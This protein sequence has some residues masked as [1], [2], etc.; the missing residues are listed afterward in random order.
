MNSTLLLILHLR[1]INDAIRALSRGVFPQTL[2]SDKDIR[3]AGRSIAKI[4]I[5]KHPSVELLHPEADYFRQNG[6]RFIAH[7]G[8]N[9]DIWITLKFQVGP[10]PAS[11]KLYNVKVYPVP[12]NNGSTDATKIK[13][14]PEYVVIKSTLD[15]KISYAP[16]TAAELSECTLQ[17]SYTCEFALAFSPVNDGS[18]VAAIIQDKPN[19]IHD[20][21]EFDYLRD[22]ITPGFV[23]ISDNTVLFY[24]IKD[25]TLLCG[26]NP[27]TQAEGCH[28]CIF[29]VESNCQ[30]V[31]NN[32]KF[33]TT[34][35]KSCSTETPEITRKHL[36]NLAV[37]KA[38]RK[39]L[40]DGVR[41][42][43]IFA[44]SQIV[45]DL[46]KIEFFDHDFKQFLASEDKAGL[47]LK[48]VAAA[49]SKNERVFQSLSEALLMGKI[50][51]DAGWINVN[52][53][54]Y[55]VNLV[56]NIILALFVYRIY[57]N[58]QALGLHLAALAG[59]VNEVGASILEQNF[60][61]GQAR[62]I[63]IMQSTNGSDTAPVM[64]THINGFVSLVFDYSFVI[65]AAL[66]FGTLLRHYMGR[67]SE[68][69][70]IYLPVYTPSFS[71]TVLV[72]ETNT[73]PYELD[74]KMSSK[75][76][77]LRVQD[78]FSFRPK[79]I[80]D[81]YDCKIISS[82]FRQDLL[83][84]DRTFYISHW[85][86]FKFSRLLRKKNSVFFCFFSRRIT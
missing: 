5:K 14:L 47:D 6:P 22:H 25:V 65:I 80:I 18:C 51:L 42:S 76:I 17:G 46:P 66:V 12:V 43:S 16:V 63:E 1:E 82:T 39:D 62:S 37:L 28:F 49:A 31:Y 81:W 41:G 71:R 34:V 84:M 70:K 10:R 50:D 3:H 8:N 35:T 52:T 54:L 33:T 75:R 48:K 61:S 13:G 67:S 26:N 72:Y 2:I 36:I 27:P 69:T 21:C 83:T 11:S 44:E 64:E 60:T 24:K 78:C 29:D 55:I 57:R 15:N 4:L 38:F 19:L 85:A 32:V 30:L 56:I 77:S 23:P 68:R 86:A 9:A 53:I 20:S 73:M 79:L 74:I 59:R 40:I 45:N 7:L 58:Y